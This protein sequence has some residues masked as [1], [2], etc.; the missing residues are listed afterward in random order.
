ML[1]RCRYR[2][3]DETLATKGALPRYAF[4]AFDDRGCKTSQHGKMRGG[5]PLQRGRYFRLSR[6]QWCWYRARRSHTCAK[7]LLPSASLPT[8]R[9]CNENNSSHPA[10]TRA[11]IRWKGPLMHAPLRETS[12]TS[13][14]IGE[15]RGFRAGQPQPCSTTRLAPS[16][17]MARADWQLPCLTVLDQLLRRCD[18]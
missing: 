1:G 7:G 5:Q 16:R 8:W 12:D 14:L 11:T 6:P 13:C 3:V 17:R 2:G 9:A 15:R 10:W 18:G 4:Y